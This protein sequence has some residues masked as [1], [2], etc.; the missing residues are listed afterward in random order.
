MGEL[1]QLYKVLCGLF[2]SLLLIANSKLFSMVEG[3]LELVRKRSKIPLEA[4]CTLG[5]AA[6]LSF[7]HTG[8]NQLAAP[9]KLCG[10]VYAKP[11]REVYIIVGCILAASSTVSV[12]YAL[13]RCNA[14]WRRR[15]HEN[16]TAHLIPCAGIYSFGN[17]CALYLRR[18][19]VPMALGT[20]FIIPA[21]A[22]WFLRN[23]IPE[24]HLALAFIFAS[25]A[26]NTSLAIVMTFTPKGKSSRIQK[27][28]DLLTVFVT[29]KEYDA[30]DFETEL[31]SSEEVR[32]AIVRDAPSI[33]IAEIAMTPQALIDLDDGASLSIRSDRDIGVFRPKDSSESW[34][35]SSTDRMQER[36]LV[37]IE[38]KH[39]DFELIP[40]RIP[41]SI[42]WY[43]T[44]KGL[45]IIG[46]FRGAQDIDK[47]L[48]WL[49]LVSV[50]SELII[51]CIPGPCVVIKTTGT[52]DDES[53]GFV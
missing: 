26:L 42:V 2:S 30:P 27:F 32:G 33:R 13:G 39:F 38:R 50:L 8:S 48:I 22:L 51:C 37:R 9:F 5:L 45:E 15:E 36:R 52:D 53:P 18:W 49:A 29:D 12:L 24:I 21:L 16:R 40:V 4:T 7:S 6:V 35:G 14:V 46:E 31:S 1:N 20:H 10:H 19:W 11:P 34:F 17:L 44:Y 28:I 41:Y 23:R 43:S 3:I 25:H 47:C